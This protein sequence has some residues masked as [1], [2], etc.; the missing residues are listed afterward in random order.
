[1]SRLKRDLTNNSQE[2][3]ITSLF[4][5]SS[6][7]PWSWTC[8]VRTTTWRPSW[9]STSPPASSTS[10]STSSS[11]ECRP[12]W[13]KTD[14]LFSNRFLV[15]FFLGR[16][17]PPRLFCDICDE[18]DLHDT[19]DCPTQVRHHSKVLCCCFSLS[20]HFKIFHTWKQTL[21]LL[22]QWLRRKRVTRKRTANVDW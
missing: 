2:Y 8:S 21:R 3:Y 13:R 19:E 16:A 15:F 4:R 5:S 1:M 17:V 12:G 20:S 7:T 6:W 22:Q 11:T 10:P 9:S 14:E 18:F